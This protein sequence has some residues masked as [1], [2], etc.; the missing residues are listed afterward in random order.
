VLRHLHADPLLPAAVLP[1]GWPG[2]GLRRAYEEFHTVF[3]G[4]WRR[5]IEGGDFEG[6][7][8]GAQQGGS[9]LHGRIVARQRFFVGANTPLT[10]H[11]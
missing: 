5:K 6:L 10:R 2:E 4:A 9:C 3:A 7:F 8:G 1:P 11:K